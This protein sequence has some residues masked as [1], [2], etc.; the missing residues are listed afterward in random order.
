MSSDAKKIGRANKKTIHFNGL[1]FNPK[2]FLFSLEVATK[3]E[4]YSGHMATCT[5]VSMFFSSFLVLMQFQLLQHFFLELYCT[6][7]QHTTGG[8]GD[9]ASLHSV[10][11]RPVVS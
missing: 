10:C 1:P 6:K 2:L 8:A 3:C 11:L 7:S 5:I 9:A 4:S